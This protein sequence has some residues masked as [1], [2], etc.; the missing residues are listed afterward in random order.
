MG[1]NES[2]K[3]CISDTILIR[4]QMQRI[5]MGVKLVCIRTLWPNAFEGL[6]TLWEAVQKNMQ[7]LY[8]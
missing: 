1:Y 5:N 3:F 6:L 4:L 2:L 7:Q 8:T